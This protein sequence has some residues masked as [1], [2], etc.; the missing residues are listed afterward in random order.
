MNR[1][2]NDRRAAWAP[3]PG[4]PTPSSANA[5]QKR[6]ALGRG[7]IHVTLT[8]KGFTQVS[9]KQELGVGQE[10]STSF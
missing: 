3:F 2:P 1:S 5:W 6:C 4:Q 7:P 9:S 10:K 8:G